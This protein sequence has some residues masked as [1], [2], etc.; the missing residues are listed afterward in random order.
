MRECIVKGCH[1]VRHTRGL[2]KHHY[3]GWYHGKVNIEPLPSLR[4]AGRTCKI[5]GCE[6][7]HDARGLCSTHYSEALGR[8]EFLSA[9]RRRVLN[10]EGYARV[11][12]PGHP[13]AQKS[14]YILEHVWVMSDLLGRALIKGENVH[15]KNGDKLDNRPQNLELWATRQCKG[16]RV[17]DL[18]EWALEILDRYGDG[19]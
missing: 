1:G 2:C 14:G 6:R 9:G 5:E 7:K 13:N 3:D 19:L 18:V 16:A 10:G 4:Q 12:K 8:G 15:H 11:W 17:A